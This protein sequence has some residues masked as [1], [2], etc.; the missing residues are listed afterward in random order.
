MNTVI[1]RT[2]TTDMAALD[3]LHKRAVAPG[4]S[5]AQSRGRAGQP[6]APHSASLHAGYGC[7]RPLPPAPRYS[8]M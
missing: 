6:N 3:S 4:S 2:N 5:A 1:R 8:E 7:L